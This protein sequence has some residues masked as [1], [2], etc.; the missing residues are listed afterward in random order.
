MNTELKALIGT[1]FDGEKLVVDTLKK[2]YF[3]LIS[4]AMAVM[5]DV[6]ADIGGFS[7]LQNEIKEL[8][9]PANEADLVAFVQQKFASVQVL[10]SAKAQQVISATVNLISAAI[11]VEQAFVS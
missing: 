2:N 6:P 9:N 8:S 5:S 4:D 10:S 1:A 3:S 7:D 11:A